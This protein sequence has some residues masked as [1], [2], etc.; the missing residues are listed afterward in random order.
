M[1]E[2]ITVQK[3]LTGTRLKWIAMIVMLI[4]HA[5]ATVF[6][7]YIAGRA[8]PL[9][10]STQ[11][12]YY[13]YR[14]VGRVAFPIFCFLL[15]EG[16][17]HTRSRSRY[18]RNLVVFSLV[19]EIPFDLALN[20]A[21]L[22]FR[23]QNVFFTLAIGLLSILLIKHFEGKWFLQIIFGF[24]CAAASQLLS[25]DYG[26]CGVILI[27]IF[28][29][30]RNNHKWMYFIG[31]IWLFLGPFLQRILEVTLSRGR[32]TALPASVLIASAMLSG[33]L[34]VFAALSFFL[35]HKYN[36]QRGKSLPK[37]FFYAFYPGHLLILAGISRLIVKVMA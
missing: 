16:F 11:I 8:E 13:I 33:G 12:F 32:H 30:F 6:I 20:G 22:E 15:V 23:S 14:I 27:I 1:E 19:S 18:L 35:I 17:L 2:T 24:A 34:E 29:I 31:S 26:A 4:D 9:G 36:G 7:H 21:V 10:L 3:G 25:T 5:A 28:Y 37:Y